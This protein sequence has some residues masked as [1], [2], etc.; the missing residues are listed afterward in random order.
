MGPTWG[1]PG[2][3]FLL[4]WFPPVVV[5]AFLPRLALV[6]ARWGPRE[7][8]DPT[9]TPQQLGALVAGP[10][11][12]VAASVA[13]LLEQG[14]LRMDGSRRLATV[15]GPVRPED[16]PGLSDVDVEVLNRAHSPRTAG[17]LVSGARSSAVVAEVDGQLVARGLLRDPAEMRRRARWALLPFGLLMVLGLARLGSGLGRSASVGFLVP[18]LVVAAF[19][20]VAAHPRARA[21]RVVTPRGRATV[22]AAR[23]HVRR[24][25]SA[26]PT[27]AG[28]VLG[29]AALLVAIGGFAAFPDPELAGLLTPALVGGGGGYDGGSSCSS[30]SCSSSSSSCGG[31]GSSCGG[32]G[33]CGG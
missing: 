3:L 7:E 9:V 24:V 26:G 29:G 30:S 13:G 21:R 33:G 28:P 31:G 27:A 25:R 12:L 16:D 19:V 10:D 14:R 18:L 20:A 23:A 4:L 2:P 6:A 5:A 17:W 11:R 22:D 1:V 8:P 15:V 32:G